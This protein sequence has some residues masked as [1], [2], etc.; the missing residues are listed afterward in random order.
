VGVSRPEPEHL[1]STTSGTGF[2][3]AEVIGHQAIGSIGWTRWVQPEG[4]QHF[5]GF[6]N[7]WEHLVRLR[8]SQPLLC[9]A[10]GVL[11]LP[12]YVGSI[13]LIDAWEVG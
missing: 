12:R 6:N 2:D 5:D 7:M 8:T 1:N 4:Y 11:L 3:G 13:G 10:N 9:Y